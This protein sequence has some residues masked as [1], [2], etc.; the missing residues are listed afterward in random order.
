MNIYPKYLDTFKSE[1]QRYSCMPNNANFP[2]LKRK[3]KIT[4]SVM[5]YKTYDL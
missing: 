1:I 5:T 3:F 4:H 2:D